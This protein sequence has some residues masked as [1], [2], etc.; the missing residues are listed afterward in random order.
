MFPLQSLAKEPDG[1]R[2][3]VPANGAQIPILIDL[4]IT[5][6]IDAILFQAFAAYRANH[7]IILNRIFALRTH[8]ACRL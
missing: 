7:E 2:L 3:V 6:R 4:V 5:I 1:L 8:F